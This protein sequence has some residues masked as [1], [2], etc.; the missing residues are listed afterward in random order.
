MNLGEI[1]LADQIRHLLIDTSYLRGVGLGGGEL[2]KLLRYSREGTLKIFIPRIVWE[3]LR[4]QL[5]EEVKT[6]VKKLRTAYEKVVEQSGQYLVLKGLPRPT[7]GLWSDADMDGSSRSALA[8]YAAEHKIQIVEIASDHATRAWERFFAVELPYNADQPRKDRRKDIPDAWILET[9]IDLVRRHPNLVAIC[10]DDRLS[11]A[12]T[13]NYV[14]V[15][16]SALEVLDQIEVSI[17]EQSST[18][19]SAKA[20]EKPEPTMAEV[21]S[22]LLPSEELA[23]LLENAQ[24]PSRK[25]DIK[26]AGFVTYLAGPTKGQLVDLLR[27]SGLSDDLI[28]N[29]IGRLVLSGIVRDTG[30]HYL[31]IDRKIGDLAAAT[32]END[33]IDLLNANP[34]NGH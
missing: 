8:A 7:L 9:A 21:E 5:L 4:T 13:A 11:V 33:I 27:R 30:N 28:S 32:V 34:S 14:T 26:I 6:D 23:Q 2:Q 19:P 22:S 31:P 1:G 25:L 16:K 24:T 15:F 17:P 3:E 29:G 18:T 20:S 12:L 10:R